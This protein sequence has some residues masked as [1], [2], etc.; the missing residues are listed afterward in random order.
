M[1]GAT[2]MCRARWWRDEQVA[3]VGKQ[4]DFAMNRWGSSIERISCCW[5][6]NVG[7]GSCRWGR[8]RQAQKCV[9]HSSREKLAWKQEA[10][11][12][13]GEVYGAQEM[14]Q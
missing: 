10:R 4:L 7:V 2:A 8:R 14:S 3:A 13:V 1:L 5:I 6:T 9:T 12:D 11:L